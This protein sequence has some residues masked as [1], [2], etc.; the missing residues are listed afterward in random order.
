M[1][2]FDALIRFALARHCADLISQ[3]TLRTLVLTKS[4]WW[5]SIQLPA[6]SKPMAMFLQLATYY[7]ELW[8]PE[9]F[10]LLR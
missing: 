4:D 1:S 9:I 5:Q 8:P 10:F 3:K 6:R 7:L 2:D